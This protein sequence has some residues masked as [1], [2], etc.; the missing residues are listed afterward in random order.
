MAISPGE[1]RSLWMLYPMLEL[2]AA[3]AAV[4]EV[5]VDTINTFKR[6]RARRLTFFATILRVTCDVWPKYWSLFIPKSREEGKS[7]LIPGQELSLFPINTCPTHRACCDCVHCYHSSSVT[8][9]LPPSVTK[10]AVSN[11]GRSKIELHSSLLYFRTQQWPCYQ[12]ALRTAQ[13]AD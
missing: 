5:T 3:G 4:D 12:L 9:V 7:A 1:M 6:V 11:C 10:M 13:H 8:L 2:E